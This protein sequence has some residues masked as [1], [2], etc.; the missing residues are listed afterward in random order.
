LILLGLLHL[1]LSQARQQMIFV[2]LAVV[3]LR[4]PLRAALQQRGVNLSDTAARDPL[5]SRAAAW[6]VAIVL[7]AAVGVRLAAPIVRVDDRSTPR[8]ALA[9]VPAALA[10]QPVLNAYNFGG[11]LIFKGVRPFIDGRADMYGDAFVARYVALRSEPPAALGRDL[12]V[13]RVA[14]TLL[15]PSDPLVGRLDRLP[16][17]RRLYG[18]A[19]GVVHVRTADADA[20]HSG[21]R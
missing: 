5:E 16:G 18:D 21:G 8:A 6:T 11:Y 14:W 7:A 1:A 10:R 9:A 4:D 15:E 2:T 13:L 17:W 3:V 19:Y 20:A 12:S